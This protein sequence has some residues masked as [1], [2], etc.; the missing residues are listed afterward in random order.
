MTGLALQLVEP[1]EGMVDAPYD[2]VERGFVDARVAAKSL[3]L[4]AV[5]FQLLQQVAFEV[6]AAGDVQDLEQRRQREMMVH[7]SVAYQ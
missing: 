2:F 6:G 4:R 7:R 3:E 5:A 1:V